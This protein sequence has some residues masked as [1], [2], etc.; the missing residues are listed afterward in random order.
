MLLHVTYSEP[1]VTFTNPMLTFSEPKVT[2]E[3]GGKV[4]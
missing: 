1:K 4:G 3:G 2:L